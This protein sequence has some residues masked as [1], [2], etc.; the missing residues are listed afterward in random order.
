MCQ[1]CVEYNKGNMT[2]KELLNNIGELVDSEKD[3]DNQKH[4][5]EL[6]DKA[7][8]KEMPFEEWDNDSQTGVLDELDRAFGS[9]ED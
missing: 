5:F 3:E 9:D 2:T 6:A 8:S 7:I 4:L 1:L